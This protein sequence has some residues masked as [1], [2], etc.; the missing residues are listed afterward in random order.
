MYILK[1]LLDVVNTGIF[2]KMK[3]VNLYLL[4]T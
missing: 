2:A 4:S 1:L 3:H